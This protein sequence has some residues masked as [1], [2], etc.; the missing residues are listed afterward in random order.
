LSH[1][2]NLVE[3]LQQQLIA[4]ATTTQTEIKMT[5]T[6]RVEGTPAAPQIQ[7]TI[8]QTCQQLGLTYDHL[9]SRASHDAQEMGKITDMG[10]IF[11]PSS[12]GISHSEEEYTSPEQCTQGTQVLFNTLLQLDA[13]Y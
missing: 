9:P 5:P 2:D 3:Q 10:M 7:H 6:L 1:V 4:I 8:V 13:L 12:A 11:V